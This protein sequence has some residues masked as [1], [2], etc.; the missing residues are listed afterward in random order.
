MSSNEYKEFFVEPF[1]NLIVSI[2][3]VIIDSDK[4]KKHSVSPTA[5]AIFEDSVEAVLLKKGSKG[6]F[7]DIKNELLRNEAIRTAENIPICNNFAYI[8]GKYSNRGRYSK[9]FN[10][11]STLNITNDFTVFELSDLQHSEILQN[12]VLMTV[13]FLVYGKMQG[14]ERRTALMIDEFWRLGKHPLLKDPIEGF[15]RRGRKYNLSLILASQCMS[16]FSKADS[17]A[18]AAA[19]AQSD[20][21]IMLSVD[22]K[23]EEMLKS[24]LKM[25][26]GE[27]EIANNLSGIKGSY[28][29]FMIRHK[30]GNWQIGRLLLDPFSA[31]LYSTKAEDVAAIKKMRAQGLSVEEA[32]EGLL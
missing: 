21:R 6:G 27:I 10:G 14:R 32:I 15:A 3:S 8:L 16:D 5:Q 26:P 28:S 1:I 20:W 12:V 31:K 13:V 23:D 29:E 7:T 19:L 9:Y 11:K 17:P 25:T 18:G 24:E 22:G 30:S 2:L 4:D